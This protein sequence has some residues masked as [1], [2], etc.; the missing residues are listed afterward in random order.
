MTAD[1]IPEELR[2]F[3]LTCGLTVPHVEALLLLRREAAAA[4]DAAH[5]GTRL[6]VGEKR[7]AQLLADLAEMGAVAIEPAGVRYAPTTQALGQMVDLLADAY[8]RHLVAVTQLIHHD[9]DA[10][11]RQFAAAFRFRKE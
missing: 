9:A 11:A 8:A 2:R 7:A 4:W 1:A 10:K 6:Y 3:L 5:L